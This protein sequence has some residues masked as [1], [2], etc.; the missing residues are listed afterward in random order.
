MN[1]LLAFDQTYAA[2]GVR[3][4]AGVDEAGRGC[5][6]GPV[7]A[8]ALVLPGGVD[9]PGVADSKRLNAAQRAAARAQIE[10]CAVGIGVGLCSPEEID[11]LNVLHAS[12]EAMRRAVLDLKDPRTGAP[13]APGFLLVDGNRLPPALPCPAEAVVKGDGRSLCVAA[14]SIVAKTTRDAL[15]TALAQDFPQ[16]GWDRHAGYPTVAHYAALAA[17][18]P[19]VHHRRTFRLGPR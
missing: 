17:H 9:L 7:V 3:V 1:P 8:A 4:L 16:Y 10:A 18:G 19:S 5:L 12:M 15:M 14:A 13:V 6:A 2:R 11:R